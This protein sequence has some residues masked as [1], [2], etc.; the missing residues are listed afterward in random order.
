MHIPIQS[1]MTTHARRH[2]D[3]VHRSVVTLAVVT[4]QVTSVGMRLIDVGVG[5][6][7]FSLELDH[8]DA[9]VEEQDR[10]RSPRFHR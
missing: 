3:S 10:V 9:S 4:A 2:K 7:L 1:V 6:D 5:W 8:D